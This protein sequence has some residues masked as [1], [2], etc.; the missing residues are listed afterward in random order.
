MLAEAA[1]AADGL[2]REFHIVGGLDMQAGLEYY[3][4]MFRALKANFP[5]VHI[6]ALTAVEIAHI[7]RIEKMSWRD[8][9]IVLRDAGL[10]TMPGGGAETFSAAVRNLEKAKSL[11]GD[12]P[13]STNPFDVVDEASK[14]LMRLAAGAVKASAS[15]VVPGVGV[16]IARSSPRSALN[17]GPDVLSGMPITCVMPPSTSAWRTLRVT[18]VGIMSQ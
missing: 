7:A 14:R 17:R 11:A 4:A 16:T 10:D 3:A 15:R 13:L 2:T 12:L 5:H 1:H 18:G 9:L 6:K 8:V